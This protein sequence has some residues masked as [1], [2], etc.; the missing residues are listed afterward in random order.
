M[1]GNIETTSAVAVNRMLMTSSS[2]TPLR[3]DERR[4]QLVGPLGDLL[5]GV[6]VDRGGAT[7]GTDG[8]V[9]RA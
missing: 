8:W 7:Q 9:S 2:S 6:V 5:G 3:S 4:Q 1:A